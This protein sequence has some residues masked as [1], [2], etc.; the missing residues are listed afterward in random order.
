MPHVEAP[1]SLGRSMPNMTD[2]AVSFRLILAPSARLETDMILV[3]CVCWAE[4]SGYFEGA[5]RIMDNRQNRT[6][7]SVLFRDD[8]RRLASAQLKSSLI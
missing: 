3:V 7:C 4:K 1:H 6:F 8:P 5:V 2:A